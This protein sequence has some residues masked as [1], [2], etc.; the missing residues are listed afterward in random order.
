MDIPLLRCFLSAAYANNFSKAAVENNISQSSFSKK[1]KALEEELHVKLF[2]RNNSKTVLTEAGECFFKHAKLILDAYQT[3]E[4]DLSTYVTNGKSIIS[5]ATIPITT[6]YNITAYL[7]EFK[8]NNPK[9]DF[10]VVEA[11][12]DVVL[13]SLHNSKCTF[14]I[15]RT[16][17]LDTEKYIIQPLVEDRLVVLMSQEHCR[18]KRDSIS[19]AD[20]VNE[21]FVFPTSQSDL[22]HICLNAC[23][24]AGF[25]PNIAFSI[26]GRIDLTLSFVRKSNAISLIMKNVLSSANLS[27][28]IAIP[29]QECICSTTAI[30]WKKETKLRPIDIDFVKYLS[31]EMSK[32]DDCCKL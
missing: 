11:E 21:R 7:A 16:D 26:S 1:I 32:N 14:A 9:T 4:R 19:L 28:L 3:M 13:S 10:H 18:A 25:S 5:I 8:M 22:Y 20:L 15:T 29:L 6:Q 2:D 12:S 27:G 30:I 24:E 23:N 31:T 17:F